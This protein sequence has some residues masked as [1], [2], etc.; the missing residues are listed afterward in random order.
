MRVIDAKLEP[1]L[2]GLETNSTSVLSK[3]FE[4]T[5]TVVT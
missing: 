1:A 4:T 2:S 3:L 5:R